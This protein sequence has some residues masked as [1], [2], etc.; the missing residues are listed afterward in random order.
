MAVRLADQYPGDPDVLIALLMNRVDLAPGEAVYLPA[1]NMDAYLS[2]FG[3]EIMA[4]SDNVL[5]GGLTTKHVDVAELFA[6]VSFEPGEPQMV[7]P[8]PVAPGEL[9]YRTPS[10]EFELSVIQ[11]APE[12]RIIEHGGPQIL[13]AIDGSPRLTDAQ[14]RC[15]VCG[16]DSRYPFP[17][18][19]DRSE[20]TEPAP[21]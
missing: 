18:D 15:V 7:T 17:Q 21:S 12:G 11:A 9:I 4:S 16:G 5:R 14:G 3:V 6:V 13:L 20:S 19:K 2:G 10:P 8:V 1:G